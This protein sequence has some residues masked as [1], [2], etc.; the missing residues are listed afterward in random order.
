MHE[1]LQARIRRDQGGEKD[2][3]DDDHARHVLGPAVAIGVAAGGRALAEHEGN[4]Q[5]N[6]RERV[7]GI[8]DGISQQTHAAADQHD[9]ELEGSSES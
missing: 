3:A 1:L 9:H 5:G 6:G 2:H 4:P 8:V 7:G